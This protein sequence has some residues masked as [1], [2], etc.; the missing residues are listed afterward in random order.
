MLALAAIALALVV[1]AV[2]LGGRDEDGGPA[3]GD[4]AVGERAQESWQGFRA[5]R[6]PGADWRPYADSSPFNQPIPRDVRVHPESSR[7]VRQILSWSL[8]AAVVGGVA[9]TRED[10]AHPTYWARRG[11]PLYTLRPS[12]D[13][14]D[15]TLAGERIHIPPE[16]TAALGDDGHLTVVQPDG[17]EYDFWRAQELDDA[18]GGILRYAAGA[19][20]RID[21]S[22]VDG[23]ATAADFGNL[24]GIIRAPELAA[25]R[26]DHALFL[27]ISCAAP[28]DSFGF[29]ATVRPGAGDSA[30][31]HPATGGGSICP[32]GVDA[33]PL[34]ARLQL[35]L[36]AAQIDALG[37]P[38][39]KRA[40]LRALARYG[41]Y[42]GDTG[43]PGVGLQIESSLTYTAFGRPD[44]LVQLA[45][46]QRASGDARVTQNGDRWLFNVASDVDWL[47]H[48][49]V[50]APPKP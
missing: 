8:P 39:W 23:G 9:G 47:R 6:W 37:L 45:Q 31:V 46:R 49:R 5:G 50:V 32:A 42:V 26:I 24:A 22:G 44:P 19:R 34:G 48:L 33:P 7:Y 25:G 4:P 35:A 38:P 2:L 40:I 18:D 27:V 12:T 14:G 36:S 15:P 21:G 17:W 11:D 10:Y 1:A 13:W 41:A 30:Y 20:L 28:T 29:D 16:A 3:A 43:G